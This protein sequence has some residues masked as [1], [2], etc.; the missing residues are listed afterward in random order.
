MVRLDSILQKSICSYWGNLS[1]ILDNIRDWLQDDI[2]EYGIVI[3]WKHIDIP[4][5]EIY[6][7]M[8]S[9]DDFW[10]IIDDEIFSTLEGEIPEF[11]EI[12]KKYWLDFQK[13][14]ISRP[15]YYNYRGDY[16]EMDYDVMDWMEKIEDSLKEYIQEY[17]DKIMIHSHSGYISFEPEHV[18]DVTKYD[19]SYIYAVLKKEWIYEKFQDAIDIALENIAGNLTYYDL[20][21]DFTL[22]YEWKKYS[23]GERSENWFICKEKEKSPVITL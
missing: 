19:E 11:K 7:D 23:I 8:Y 22:D 3:D 21:E 15:Q 12:L 13:Y 17:I 6:I 2:S 14:Y 5:R 1:C 20:Y 9:K 4:Y 10:K 16:L 18:Q